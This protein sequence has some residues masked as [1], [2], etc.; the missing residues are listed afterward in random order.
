MQVGGRRLACGVGGQ[1]G[2]FPAAGSRTEGSL[3]RWEAVS[4]WRG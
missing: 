4:A 1:P 2:A 3:A